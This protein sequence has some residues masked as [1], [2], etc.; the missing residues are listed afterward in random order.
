MGEGLCMFYH[1]IHIVPLSH[2]REDH[3]KAWGDPGDRHF[4][5]I[6]F[7]DNLGKCLERTLDQ[8]EEVVDFVFLLFGMI[9]GKLFGWVGLHL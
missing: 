7:S 6:C 4:F 8:M 5:G 1:H 3:S 2:N 9:L